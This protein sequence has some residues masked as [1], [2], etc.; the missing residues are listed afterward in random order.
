MPCT[1]QVLSDGEMIFHTRVV[2]RL[3]CF[4]DDVVSAPG[5]GDKGYNKNMQILRPVCADETKG[6]EAIVGQISRKNIVIL[7]F[8][9]WMEDTE[10]EMEIGYNSYKLSA[11]KGKI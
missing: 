3:C 7:Y 4:P 1:L 2:P 8:F 9:V 5:K 6:R 11:I 10:T